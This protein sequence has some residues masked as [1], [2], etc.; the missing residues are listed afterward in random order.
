MERNAFERRIIRAI[1]RNR[2]DEAFVGG[3]DGVLLCRE[4]KRTVFAVDSAAVLSL[5]V[6]G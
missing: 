5:Q 2:L 3:G 6:A 4:M 1:W